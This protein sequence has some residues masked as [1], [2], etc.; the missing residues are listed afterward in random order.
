ALPR[1]ALAGCGGGAGPPP[2]P[3]PPPFRRPP[4]RPPPPAP[5][6]PAPAAAAAPP[7]AAAPAAAAAAALAAHG[8]ARTAPAATTTASAPPPAPPAAHSAAAVRLLEP[9]HILDEVGAIVED[10]MIAR[11]IVRAARPRVDPVA[12]VIR[13]LWRGAGVGG[14]GAGGGWPRAPPAGYRE[15]PPKARPQAGRCRCPRCVTATRA[16]DATRAT[17]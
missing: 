17:P 14:R 5:A 2:R 3:A 7:A 13:P 11:A 6:A 15:R 10:A 9:A 12:A 1:C 16:R 4:P 8:S